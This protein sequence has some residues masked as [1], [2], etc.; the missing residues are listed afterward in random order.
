MMQPVESRRKALNLS[1]RLA[2]REKREEDRNH[3]QR[4]SKRETRGNPIKAAN[5]S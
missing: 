5:A 2:N 1:P 4:A 3:H